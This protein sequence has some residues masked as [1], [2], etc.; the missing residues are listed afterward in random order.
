MSAVIGTSAVLGRLSIKDLLK[1]LPIF[2]L[3]YSFNEIIIEKKIQA[4]DPG[5]TTLIFTFGSMFALLFSFI[6]GKKQ[7]PQRSIEEGHYPY[8]LAFIGVFILWVCWPLFN[9]G[10]YPTNA[11]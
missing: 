4:S 11:F 6:L 2:V 7:V 3:G 5:G 8:T 9:C 10:I 1:I